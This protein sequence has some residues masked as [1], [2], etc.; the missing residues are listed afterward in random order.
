MEGRYSDLISFK[1]KELELGEILNESECNVGHRR[2]MIDLE[3]V[4]LEV[5]LP[6]AG[7]MG[8]SNMRCGN[9]ETKDTSEW[10][11]Q[12]MEERYIKCMPASAVDK[13]IF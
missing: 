7:L 1:L 13:C 11:P 2:K 10:I 8:G 12:R 9:N 3:E 4:C 5:Q 6:G